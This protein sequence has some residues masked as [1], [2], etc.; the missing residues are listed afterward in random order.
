MKKSF[1]VL[2]LLFTFSCLCIWISKC[3]ALNLTNTKAAYIQSYN[4][5]KTGNY[6]DAIR[7]LLSVYDQ[8]PDPYMANLRLGW[9][10]YLYG[11]Y[12]N[13]IS[14]YKKA[15]KIAPEA[16][17]PLLG[18]SLPLIAQGR[19]KEVETLMYEVLRKDFYNYYGNLRLAIALRHQKKYGQAEKVAQ[20][21][22][23]LYPSDT[24]FLLELGLTQKSKGNIKEARQIFKKVLLLDP[25][26]RVA[27][28]SINLLYKTQ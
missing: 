3:S 5:E 12:A 17:E 14:F 8:S 18:M 26:N 19:F 10:Y 15:S 22:L 2:L 1:L 6:R 16:I 25:L 24:N 9:L 7:S 11:R 23:R 28:Y 4:Y 13:S 21:M 20:K 27:T